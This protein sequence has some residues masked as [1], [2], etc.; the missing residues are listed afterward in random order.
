MNI[1]APCEFCVNG[2]ELILRR[3][4]YA[5]NLVNSARKSGDEWKGICPYCKHEL[6]ERFNKTCCGNCGNKIIWEKKQ[7]EV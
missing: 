3:F 1:G 6:M 4:G 7:R 5:V 2:D